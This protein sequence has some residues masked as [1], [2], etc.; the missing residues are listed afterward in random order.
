MFAKIA[1]VAALMRYYLEFNAV[2]K[3]YNLSLFVFFLCHIF[4]FYLSLAPGGRFGRSG[5]EH[6]AAGCGLLNCFVFPGQF[7]DM[8]L[9]ACV[10]VQYL[11]FCIFGA[12]ARP[13][14]CA[15][16]FAKPGR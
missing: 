13:Q 3:R 4:Y 12:L 16:C 1:F 15:V 5:Q 7:V 6:R 10:A 8:N 9:S 2:V 11:I 14:V